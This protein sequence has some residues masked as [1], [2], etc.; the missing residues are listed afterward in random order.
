MQNPPPLP[1]LT[2]AARAELTRSGLNL[3]PQAISI[4][5]ADLRLVAGNRA[6]QVMFELPDTLLHPGT[7][8]DETIRVLY[9]RGEYGAVADI[10]AA[11]S[12]RLAQ[13]RTFQPHY[14]ERTRP[15][16]QTISVEGAPLAEGGWIA[17]YT[18]ITHTRRQEALL[19][20]RSAEL[21]GQVLDHTERLAAA[22]RALAATNAALEEMGRVLT[23]AEAR[24]R[25]VTAMVP[26][27]IAHVDAAMRYTFSNN[28]LAEV[29]PGSARRVVGLTVAEALGE[30]NW[31]RIAPHIRLALAGAPQVFEMTHEPSGRRVRIALTPDPAAEGAGV[32]VLSTDVSAEVQAR[33]ALT[34]AAR[35]ALAAQMT[36]GL[37]HDFGNLMTIILAL[38]DRL[39]R[40]GLPAE[41]LRDVEATTAAARRGTALLSGIA[42]MTA[43]RDVVPRPVELGSALSGLAAMA[44]PSLGEGVRLTLGLDLPE[45]PAM[46]DLG[47][48][49]DSLLNL[50]LNARDALARQEGGGT[51]TLSA[52]AAGPW[53]TLA[54]EDDGP[55]FTPE[56]LAQGTRPF[57]TTKPGQGTGLGLST[58][59]DQTKLAG[60]TLRLANTGR[61]ARVTIRLPWRPVR[62]LMVLLVDDEPDI[63]ARTRDLLTGMGHAVIE[64]GSLGEARGLLDLPGLGLVLSDI[65]LGDGFGTDLLAAL[66]AGLP[67]L[68]MTAL[69]ASDPQRLAA[70]V[71]V[72][73]KPVD[74]GTL[75]ARLTEIAD[76]R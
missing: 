74:A 30:A 68:L 63:R 69:P 70:A 36:S 8:F 16:G 60:G 7:G 27:H 5:D 58:V 38:Q 43:P 28:Q 18:D 21:S 6:Y 47:M 52:R 42:A 62:P 50:I 24:T 17:V 35:R 3:I 48:V 23:Q 73:Q 25:Q 26:A 29:F 11:V 51:I 4:F 55:G 61:G 13:A 34:H 2:D 19:R 45:G 56:A 12:A 49:Q 41:A 75:A 53:L 39:G 9:E 66:P 1:I 76:A 32:Y 20:A 59:Y 40:A 10:D 46:L 65:Q 31:A 64:A 54:V 71:P 57:F 67:A 15:N 37:A 72:L 22:N 44:G 33:E 14:L